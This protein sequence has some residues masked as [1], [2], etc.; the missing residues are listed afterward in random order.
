[1]AATIPLPKCTSCGRPIAPS[2]R[3]TS[4]RCPNCGEAVIWRC[5][6][7][8]KQ[9]NRYVCPKCGFEGP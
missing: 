2:Q 9:G 4:F 6:K 5:E 7:C 1:M 3:A 8:R